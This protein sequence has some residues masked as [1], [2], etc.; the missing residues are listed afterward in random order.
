MAR[1]KQF[2]LKFTKNQIDVIRRLLAGESLTRCR[3]RFIHVRGCSPSDGTYDYQNG[4]K[5]PYMAI[6]PLISQDIV[7]ERRKDETLIIGYHSY[8]YAYTLSED[9]I[10]GILDSVT[11]SG[12]SL[13]SFIY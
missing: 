4:D 7:K 8:T 11:P 2:A 10:R 12:K 6:T 1:Y 13:I 5:A 3:V 9:V